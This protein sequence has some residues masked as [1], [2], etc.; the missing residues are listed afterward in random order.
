MSFSGGCRP[1]PD[2]EIA[3]MRTFEKG[4]LRT[5]ID[6]AF[7]LSSGQKL[8]CYLCILWQ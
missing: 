6:S 4:D 8:A 1:F 3:D 2:S 7:R 5:Q